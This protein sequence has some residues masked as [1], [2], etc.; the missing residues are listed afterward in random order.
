MFTL[1]AIK[2]AIQSQARVVYSIVVLTILGV[3]LGV[4]IVITNQGTAF[5]V[6]DTRISK[7]DFN[8]RVEM[9]TYFYTKVSPDKVRADSVRADTK[10]F[11]VQLALME[12]ELKKYGQQITAKE[13]DDSYASK[14]AARGGLTQY[15]SYIKET[16][17][18]EPA[19][20]KLGLKSDLIKD[21]LLS[22]DSKAHLYG[23]WFNKKSPGDK[24]AKDL[25]AEETV[26]NAQVKSQAE[27]VLARVSAGENFASLAQQFSQDPSSKAR[28]G[29]LGIYAHFSSQASFNVP[30]Q[31]NTK[32]FP[33]VA[34]MDY[35]LQ[36]LGEG[37][38][39]VFDY[40]SGYA[41]IK[42]TEVTKGF[43]YQTVEQFYQA[44]K[45]KADIVVLVKI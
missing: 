25:S 12:Q 1:P 40:L 9:Q 43:D 23:I 28:G 17:S 29:D 11:F 27:A 34:V 41:V 38:A 6:N 42:A 14:A 32:V 10:D 35:A 18:M 2:K 33:S 22:H 31:P 19:D 21:K 3:I 26:A 24:A 20:I 8:R 44:E 45:K 7:A 5:I 37:E 36:Q 16:Y 13:I 15:G 39:K 30:N 4:W